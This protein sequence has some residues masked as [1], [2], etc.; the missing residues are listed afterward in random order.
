MVSSVGSII[1]FV[2]L[3]F[4]IFMLWEALASQ[5]GV[6]APNNIVTSLE[7][8]DVTPLGFH[9][10]SESGVITN[11]CLFGEQKPIWRLTVN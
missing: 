8:K 7:W 10:M 2:A 1:S 6:V 5:R 9:N 3:L 11:P 4:F